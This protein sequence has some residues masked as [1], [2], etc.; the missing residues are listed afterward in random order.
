MRSICSFAKDTTILT[1]FAGNVQLRFSYNFVNTDMK[2]DA[3]VF[4]ISRL[5]P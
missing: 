5:N 3:T 1:Q 4:Y 2:P